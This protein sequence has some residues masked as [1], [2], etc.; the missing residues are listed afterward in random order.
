MCYQGSGV[1]EI[2]YIVL[3][4]CIRAMEFSMQLSR[5]DPCWCPASVYRP[6]TIKHGYAKTW[7][8]SVGDEYIYASEISFN[9]GLGNGLP[10]TLCQVIIKRTNANSLYT[11]QKSIIDIR[12]VEIHVFSQKMASNST[13][14]GHGLQR[15]QQS[16]QDL[17]RRLVHKIQSHDCFSLK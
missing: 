2:Q 11:I 9:I 8:V 1:C 14:D 6:V 7:S 12:N 4:I 15:V 10:P 3:T 13:L 5:Y 17:S 16:F